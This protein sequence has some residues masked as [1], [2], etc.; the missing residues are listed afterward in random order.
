M[1]EIEF[2]RFTHPLEGENLPARDL[3][4]LLRSYPYVWLQF[5]RHLGCMYCKGLVKDIRA[6]L[7]SWQDSIRPF[8]VFVHPNTLEEGR[9]FFQRFYPG[10]V[11]VAD[12]HQ[13][14]YRLFR[15]RRLRGFWDLRWRDLWE[16]V[17]LWR[18][19]LSNEW[20]KADP[21]VLHASFLFRG[22]QLVWYY[23]AN[24]LSDVPNWRKGFSSARAA[25][26]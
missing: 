6:F 4:T 24:S 1:S 17:K 13:R 12:P 15:V 3:P 21:L 7:E 2:W 9:L 23:Y 11:H 14:L 10:A 22:G 18:R 25:R 20:P 26:A 16:A 5:L 8:L 19:G